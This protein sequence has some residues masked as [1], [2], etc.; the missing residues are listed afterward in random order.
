[1]T[2]SGWRRSLMR[3]GGGS[4]IAVALSLG[5]LQTPVAAQGGNRI[6]GEVVDEAGA[7]VQAAFVTLREARVGVAFTAYTNPAGRYS[8]G[9]VP[10]G[11]YEATARHAQLGR[12]VRGE[13]AYD[14]GGASWDFS[15][16]GGADRYGSG[17]TFLNVIPDSDEKR[18]FMLDCTNCH[19]FNE[20]IAFPGDHARS[21]RAWDE[22]MTRMVSKFG[23]STRFPIISEHRNPDRHSVWI[24]SSMTGYPSSAPP[25]PPVPFEL[26][27][28]M[29][30]EYEL[31][32]ELDLPHDLKVD[33]RGQVV[34]TGQHTGRMYVLNPESG[35]FRQVS[36]PVRRANPRALDIGPDGRWWVALGDPELL[37]GFDPVTGAWQTF[38]IGS[39]PHSLQVDGMGSIWFNGH[40]TVDPEIIGSLDSETGKVTAYEVPPQTGDS[41]EQN[42]V[43]YGLRVAPDGKVWG[44]ELRG[45][46]LLRVDPGTGDVDTWTLPEPYS[47]PRRL[48]IGADGTVWIPEY[49]GGRLLRFDPSDESFTAYDLPLK[50]ALPY[51]V[52]VDQQRGMVWIGTGAADAILAFQPAREHFTIFPLPTRGALIRHI[53]IVEEAG[54]VW[55][56]Y[57]ASPG[58]PSKILRIRLP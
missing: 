53:D 39:Y 58:V 57:S 16:R 49:A 14:G 43:P 7:P 51:V 25:L 4:L 27:G 22:A 48:D 29:L 45:N 37:A 9:G 28:V 30:T 1:M 55:A 19:V 46:R 12:E 18:R 24:A 35:A 47:G 21:I 10:P 26:A 31:P 41:V 54:E 33:S 17:A 42:T 36:I 6:S 2:T 20:R 40:F 8:L 34:I 5:L 32:A 44:T 52:R 50:D 11:V 3:R 38:P 15:L 13:L 56:S 23:S